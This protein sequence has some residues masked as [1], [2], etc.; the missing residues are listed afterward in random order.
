MIVHLPLLFFFLKFSLS[1]FLLFSNEFFHS[2]AWS[3]TAQAEAK[4]F[5][6]PKDEI[7]LVDNRHKISKNSQPKEL[8]KEVESTAKADSI[9]NA[10]EI[11]S[12]EQLLE[13]YHQKIERLTAKCLELGMPLEA[14]I[15]KKCWLESQPGEFVIQIVPSS[16]APKQLPDDASSLQKYWFKTYCKLRR[17]YAI[18]FFQRAEQ[19]ASENRGFDAIQLAY[20]ALNIDPDYEPVRSVFGYS[21]YNEQWRTHWEIRQLEKGFIDH[22]HFGWIS[23]DLVERYNQGERFYRGKWVSI[24]KET[25]LRRQNKDPWR[26]ETE[27]YQ[28]RTTLSLE[29][30]VRIC[31]LLEDY[32]EVW[33]R[34][35]Y[36]FA[37][38]NKEWATR[39]LNKKI[40]ATQRHYIILYQNRDEYLKEL[41]SFDQNIHKSSGGYFPEVKCIFVYEPSDPDDSALDEML[42]HEAT[43]QLFHEKRS[44]STKTNNLKSIYP[45]QKAN[46]WV[47]EGI[48]VYMESFRKKGD[49]YIIGGKDNYRFQRAKERCSEPNGY[50][51]LSQYASLSMKSFQNNDNVPMLYTQAA[52]LT[53]FFLHYDNEKYHNAFIDYLFLVYNEQDDLQTLER[54][55]QKTFEEL[56]LEYNNYMKP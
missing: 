39:F 34:F 26:I 3:F 31:R 11:Q 4:T 28:L 30:G 38:T 5:S 27:H 1:I 52:G 17:D 33:Q 23:N 10:N 6:V 37:A 22:Q 9:Q 46:F 29:E 25:E 12:D 14:E 40:N 8:S 43:H 20:L 49:L 18:H 55:T 24:Q 47:I 13:L 19:A 48:S 45:G 21:L 51:P 32:Y 50:L 41:I 2:S 35:F 16:P 7:F 54:L 53:S 44:A 15:T 42:I 56:D 36:R